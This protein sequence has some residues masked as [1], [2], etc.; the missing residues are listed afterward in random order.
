MADMINRLM[1]AMQMSMPQA[2]RDSLH[3]DFNRVYQ[4]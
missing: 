4:D 1:S 2:G 3:Y